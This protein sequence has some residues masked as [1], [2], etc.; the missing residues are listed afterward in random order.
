MEDIPWQSRNRLGTNVAANNIRVVDY[1]IRLALLRKN[2]C[3]CRRGTYF[4]TSIAVNLSRKILQH[5][6]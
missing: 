5:D 1:S 2:K 6:V 3:G 4:N